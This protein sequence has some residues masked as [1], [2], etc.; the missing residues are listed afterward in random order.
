MSAG[1]LGEAYAWVKALHIIFV[2]FWMAGLFMLPRFFAYHVEDMA[3]D[4]AMDAVWQQRELRLQRIILTPA[5]LLT[6]LFGL[7]LAGHLGVWAAPWF[8]A[9]MLMVLALSALHGV[10]AK[11]RKDFVRKSNTRSSRFYRLVNEVPSFATIVII[12]LVILQPW[13]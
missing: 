13:M 11:W 2:I 4:A 12:L 5:M 1:F 3:R 9:K 7:L 10:M 8:S 6:W